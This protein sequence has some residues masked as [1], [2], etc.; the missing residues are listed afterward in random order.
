MRDVDV[1]IL[2]VTWSKIIEAGAGISGNVACR[3]PVEDAALACSHKLD[4]EGEARANDDPRVGQ[5]RHAGKC[6]CERGV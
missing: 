1:F 4:T 6:W 5:S 3:S 2:D